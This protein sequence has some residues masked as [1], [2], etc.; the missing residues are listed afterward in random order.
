MAHADKSKFVF[1]HTDSASGKTP[2]VLVYKFL[3]LSFRVFEDDFEHFGKVL[4]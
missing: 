4:S 1:R 3:F 2:R